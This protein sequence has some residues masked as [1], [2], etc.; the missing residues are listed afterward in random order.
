MANERPD[1]ADQPSVEQWPKR[2]GPTIDLDPAAVSDDTQKA[3]RAGAF[4]RFSAR[5]LI[6][7]LLPP[8]SGA[9]AA[10]LVLGVLWLNGLIGQ[11]Q[12]QPPTVSPSQF[13]S[14]AANVGDLSARLARLEAVAARPPATPVDTAMASRLDALERTLADL[15]NDLAQAKEQNAAATATVN[16]LKSATR[17]GTGAPDLAPLT[18]RL[19]RLEQAVKTLTDTGRREQAAAGDNSLRRLA[20]ASA[21]DVA[22]RDGQPFQAALTAAKQVA[23]NPPLL[24]PLE[25][26]AAKG[27]PSEANTLR[28]LLALLQQIAAAR[29]DKGATPSKGN[30]TSDKSLQAA[31]PLD[32]LRSRLTGLVR[33]ERTD[34]APVR[35]NDGAP[36]AKSI[37]AVARGTDLAAVKRDLAKL[38]QADDPRIQAW[39]KAADARE[40]ALAASR[41]FAAEALAAAAQSGQ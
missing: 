34:A 14:V 8:L 3:E 19:S 2:S 11:R 37:E 4:S 9:V 18:E 23:G 39:I 33:I 21:L 6:D 29:N 35:A 36:P 26:F 24:A 12:L 1:G 41:Q 32:W 31:G 13:E 16:D 27:I 22:V 30:S 28:E 25:P 17:E 15:R 38:P 5:T 10:L 40:A 7:R 20:V